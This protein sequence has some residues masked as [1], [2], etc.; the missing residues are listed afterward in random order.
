MI[1]EESSAVVGTDILLGQG[2]HVAADGRERRAQLVRH[3]RHEVAADLIG[4]PEIGDV[5]QDDNDAAG[6]GGLEAGVAR[7]RRGASDDDAGRIARRGEL[8]RGWGAIGERRCDE[9]R[10]RRVTNRLDIGTSESDRFRA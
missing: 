9:L 2:F 10:D 5:V 6:S 1:G 4:P 3:V 7:G 8:Q